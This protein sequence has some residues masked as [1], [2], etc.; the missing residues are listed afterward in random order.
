MKITIHVDGYFKKKYYKI[1]KNHKHLFKLI[2]KHFNFI[3]K[4][5]CLLSILYSHNLHL[6]VV[7]KYSKMSHLFTNI[8]KSHCF[9]INDRQ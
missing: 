6:V 1:K 8:T 7:V 9:S 4:L 5:K 3:I 2:N